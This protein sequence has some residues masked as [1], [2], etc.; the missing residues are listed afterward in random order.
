M[1]TMMLLSACGG[2]PEQSVDGKQDLAAYE[3]FQPLEVPLPGYMN[4]STEEYAKVDEN[5]FKD[6]SAS[7]VSTFSVDVDRASYSNVKRFIEGGSLPPVDAVRIEELVNYFTYNYPTPT[8]KDPFAITAE[9][10]SCPWNKDH[11]LAVIGLQAEKIE[12]ENLPPS[13][14]V[15]LLDVSG[16]MN[17]PNKLPLVK[18]SLTLL[19]QQMRAQDKVAIVVYAGAAGLVLPATS[20]KKEIVNALDKLEAGGSTAGSEGIKLAYEVA[21]KNF[22]TKGNNR[23]ILCTDGDFNVGITNDNELE[24]F[25]EKQRES[26]IYLTCLGFGMGNYKDSK[27]EILADK[28]NGNYAYINDLYEAKKSLVSEF[29]GTL[30]TV[31]KDVKI[32]VEFNP[33]KVK[34]Y[35]LIGYENRML[36]TEDF[37]NDKKDAGE[38][39]AGH[40]VTAIY[41]IV[42]AGAASASSGNLKYQTSS[43]SP[44]AAGGEILTLKSRYKQPSDSVSVEMVKAVNESRAGYESCSENFRWAS[45]VA[46]FGMLLRN[47]QY[48]GAASYAQVIALAQGAKGADAEG[49][50][51]EFIRLAG[52]AAELPVVEAGK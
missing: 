19:T 31:A 21:A 6:V 4:P 32:Q 48:K 17:E 44:A 13:N 47:S 52:L 18:S 11:Q 8:G 24:R 7:P 36:N 26:G 37:T 51:S 3:R 39:G 22:A 33:A 5:D 23:V 45:S 15:F 43:L 46:M 1:A 30:F 41:E 25:I 38:M 20:D 10:G 42:P 14:I 29:G 16:S 28:G 9:V 35:R 34:S 12:T 40:T 50:R 49:Y 27:M 2:R